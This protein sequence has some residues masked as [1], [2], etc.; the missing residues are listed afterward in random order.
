MRNPWQDLP[1]S[2]PYLLQSDRNSVLLHN[3]RVES[4]YQIRYEVLPEPY[5]GRPNAPV[6][7]L[8]LNP[9][10]KDE[11]LIFYEQEHV[12]KLWRKNI[13]HEDME[14]PFYLLDPSLDPNLGGTKWWQKK[15]KELISMAGGK[16]VA[17][18]ICC[19][20]FFPYH[21]LKYKGLKKTVGSQVYG[22]Y[23]VHQAIQNGTTIIVMR[24]EKQWLDAV[25]EL[26]QYKKLYH[27]NN[28]QQP[29]ISRNN[30]PLGFPV[31]EHLL[32]G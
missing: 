14:Y 22:F 3:K 32:R 29:Y 5:L 16:N 18:N 9:G 12:R 31:I 20:E 26:S 2:S 10:F 17:N 1:E 7:L 19:V 27:L 13:L 24:K 23:L 15:L 21:S 30:C 28:N 8:G 4:D 6:M 11:D 25:P